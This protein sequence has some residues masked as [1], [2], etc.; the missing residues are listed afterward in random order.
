MVRLGSGRAHGPG[1]RLGG[2]QV[3]DPAPITAEI[4]V[5]IPGVGLLILP[6][7]IFVDTGTGGKD[8]HT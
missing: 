3:T 5:R 8:T 2:V 7:E 4:R 6:L 1:H